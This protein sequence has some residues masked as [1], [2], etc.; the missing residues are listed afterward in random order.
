MYG[1]T[2]VDNR[3]PPSHLPASDRHVAR[4]WLRNGRFD[5]QDNTVQ[6]N[7]PIPSLMIF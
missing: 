3:I 6:T 4:A 1:I 5:G 7:T 2:K